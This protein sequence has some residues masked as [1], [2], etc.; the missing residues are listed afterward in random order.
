MPQPK[1]CLGH[2][3]AASVQHRGHGGANRQARN[4]RI[5]ARPAPGAWPCHWRLARRCAGSRRAAQHDL[6]AQDDPRPLLGLAP[7]QVLYKL[8]GAAV[9]PA[10]RGQGLQ[11]QLISTARGVGR[12]CELVR[13]GSP[14]QCAQLKQPAGLRF[15][16]ARAAVPPRWPCALPAGAGAGRG[17][18]A[19]GARP[20]LAQDDIPGQEGLLAQG[21]APG[22]APGSLRLVAFGRRRAAMN[23]V[24]DGPRGPGF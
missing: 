23:A 2:A 1:T 5:P 18:G 20:G 11:R 3:R 14:R 22:Q 10:W 13:H 6:L 8:A 16:G 17:A 19:R 4:A 21:I 9:A 24:R 7:G 12:R 15:C